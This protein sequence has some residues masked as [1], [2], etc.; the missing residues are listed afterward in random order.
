MTSEQ[1]PP[2]QPGGLETKGELWHVEPPPGYTLPPL[3][4]Q[5][6]ASRRRPLLGIAVTVVGA[7]V[8]GLV[9]YFLVT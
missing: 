4:T 7:V 8:V 1:K 9:V 2:D 5:A 6:P 3:E